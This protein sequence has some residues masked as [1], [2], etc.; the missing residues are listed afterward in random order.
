MDS[1]ARER[2]TG[3]Y[4]QRLSSLPYLHISTAASQSVSES[5]TTIVVVVVDEPSK[6]G[7]ASI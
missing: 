3:F 4:Y 5:G 2:V 1:Q 6:K 7:N